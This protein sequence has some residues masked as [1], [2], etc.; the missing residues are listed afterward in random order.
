MVPGRLNRECPIE[1]LQLFLF[2]AFSPLILSLSRTR[3][4]V[5]TSPVQDSAPAASPIG[6]PEATAP[7]LPPCF[8]HDSERVGV[9]VPSPWECGCGD[10]DMY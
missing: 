8:R 10:H 2:F 9:W 1:R 7:N 6:A 4:S 3:L 5:V